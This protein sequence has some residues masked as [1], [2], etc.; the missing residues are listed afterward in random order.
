MK[1]QLLRGS[2]VRVGKERLSRLIEWRK[3]EPSTE[4]PGEDG[5]QRVQPALRHPGK[6]LIKPLQMEG[7]HPFRIRLKVGP[8]QEYAEMIGSK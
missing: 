5:H 6:Q 4:L 7:T 3:K 8:D 1:E 2:H